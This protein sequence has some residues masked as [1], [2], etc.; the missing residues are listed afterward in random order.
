MSSLC[1]AADSR[2]GC[3]CAC[4]SSLRWRVQDG[5]QADDGW[6]S[7]AIACELRH[8]GGKL[9]KP[10]KD[11]PDLGGA[12]DRFALMAALNG[13]AFLGMAMAP[14]QTVL[15]KDKGPEDPSRYHAPDGSGADAGDAEEEEAEGGSSSSSSSASLSEEEDEDDVYDEEG[16]RV[17][18]KRRVASFSLWM[19]STRGASS[20]YG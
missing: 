11:Q 10:A 17:R 2:Q 20:R 1:P 4:D 3:V 15:T 8:A 7:A 12:F 18:A 19:E 13:S 5:V 9:F 14:F 16:E 6:D